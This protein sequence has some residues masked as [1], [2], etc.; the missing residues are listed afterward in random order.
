MAV[1]LMVATMLAS[2]PQCVP[3][4]PALERAIHARAK[5]HRPKYRKHVARAVSF[6]ALRES[7]R[8][9]IP[10]LALVAVA[11]IESGYGFWI[12]GKAGELGLWQ[13]F[14]RGHGV[15]IA[16][17]KPL[18]ADVVKARHGRTGAFTKRELQRNI[19]V[20]AYVAAGEMATHVNACKHAKWGH[21]LRYSHGRR[22][23]AT[24]MKPVG[25]GPSIL[26]RIGHYNSG[27]KMPSW[28][29]LRKLGRAYRALK[30]LACQ[31]VRLAR[32]F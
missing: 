31:P 13:L 18:P 19:Y 6:A 27:A 29:Y 7:P 9:G 1:T 23:R 25:P 28:S 11:D 10:A 3:T 24:H 17:K 20:Q 22:F 26:G 5:W 16:M 21:P 14:I 8:S 4:Q 12:K 2:Q 32:R 15:R 30:K